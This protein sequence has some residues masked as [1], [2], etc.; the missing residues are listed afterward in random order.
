MPSQSRGICMIGDGRFRV[1]LSTWAACCG[2]FSF[3]SYSMADF[4][5]IFGVNVTYSWSGDRVCCQPLNGIL[6][7][8]GG[9]HPATR[10]GSGMSSVGLCLVSRILPKCTSSGSS[11]TENKFPRRKCSFLCQHSGR[12]HRDRDF[13][14]EG[15]EVLVTLSWTTP[16][17]ST[18]DGL[19]RP[20]S[21]TKQ[22]VQLLPEKLPWVCNTFHLCVHRSGRP[23]PPVGKVEHH[24]HRL[25]RRYPS[26]RSGI[27]KTTNS[28]L[29]SDIPH[30]VSRA[31]LTHD[32]RAV[33]SK[34]R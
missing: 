7:N 17:S 25:L 31:E 4:L 14:A 3:E 16:R 15:I 29:H 11:E 18:H 1:I 8:I 30:D 24:T 9:V 21:R 13:A 5:M 32:S 6:C 26:R 23:L 19:G 22:G 28:H 2:N 10:L 27:A 12:D 34:T 33:L 20:R